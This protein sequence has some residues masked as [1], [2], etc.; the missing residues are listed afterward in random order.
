MVHCSLARVIRQIPSSRLTRSG[1]LF[2]AHRRGN[3]PRSIPKTEGMEI[4]TMPNIRRIRTLLRVSPWGLADS[5]RHGERNTGT[6]KPVQS[7][8]FRS[9]G[10]SFVTGFFKV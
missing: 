9:S 2:A 3:P 6:P 1:F 10:F 5:G 4:E 7:V 8:V